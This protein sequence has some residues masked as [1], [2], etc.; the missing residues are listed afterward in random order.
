MMSMNVT[1]KQYAHF[2]DR[3]TLREGFDVKDRDDNS[4]NTYV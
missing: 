4:P 1:C 3:S 2:R